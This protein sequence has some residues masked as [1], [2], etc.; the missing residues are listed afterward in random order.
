VLFFSY[1]FA[2][3]VVLMC[4]QLLSSDK[5]D[6]AALLACLD[7]MQQSERVGLGF[8]WDTPQPHSPRSSAPPSQ[9]NPPQVQPLQQHW[10]QD[11]LHQQ[12]LQ[13]P[14]QQQGLEQ[15]QQQQQKQQQQQGHKTCSPLWVHGLVGVVVAWDHKEAAW[16]H[17]QGKHRCA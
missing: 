16:L 9:S 5:M 11:H 17:L 14:Q 6:T 10:R 3:R 15:G 7:Q 12:P 13:H 1:T 2:H 8:I 4:S